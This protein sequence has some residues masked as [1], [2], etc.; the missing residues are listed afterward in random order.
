MTQMPGA[1]AD[2]TDEE[3]G[4]MDPAEANSVDVCNDR[5]L[6][7]VKCGHRRFRVIYTR[8]RPGEIVVRRR[9]C[10]NCGVRITTWERAIGLQGHAIL[11]ARTGN[12]R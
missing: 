6:R 4:L 1:L 7:C 12:R 5:G 11:A 3:E 9:E 8:A 2:H 10:L